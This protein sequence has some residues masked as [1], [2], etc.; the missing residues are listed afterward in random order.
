MDTNFNFTDSQSS[1]IPKSSLHDG[2]ID[3]NLFTSHGVLEREWSWISHLS[4]ALQLVKSISPSKLKSK[5]P[6]Q[7]SQFPLGMYFIDF[8]FSFIYY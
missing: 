4:D 7:N 1:I 2:P 5:E 3:P 6:F 8:D